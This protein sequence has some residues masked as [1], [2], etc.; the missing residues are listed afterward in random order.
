ME[1]TSVE[2]N[3]LIVD[4]ALDRGN[5]LSSL[6]RSHHFHPIR[7]ADGIRAL[8]EASNHQPHA[9]LLDLGLPGEGGFVVLERL[10]G[11]RCCQPFR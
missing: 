7:A 2:T 5:L 9:I 1:R 6:L 11:N 10:K 4:D 8:S 3:V